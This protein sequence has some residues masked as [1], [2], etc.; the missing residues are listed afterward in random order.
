MAKKSVQPSRGT[1]A[2]NGTDHR[3]HD[4]QH[5]TISDH[6]RWCADAAGL[7]PGIAINSKIRTPG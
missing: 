2:L 4:G 3:S 1:E 6:I 7:K 5:H